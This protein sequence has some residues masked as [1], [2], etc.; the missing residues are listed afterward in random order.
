M[1][2]R[3][4][5]HPGDRH[6]VAGSLRQKQ[7]QAILPLSEW[8]REGLGSAD[9]PNSLRKNPLDS[10]K[11]VG[12]VR[13]IWGAVKGV[14]LEGIPH[15]LINFPSVRLHPAGMQGRLPR[16]RASSTVESCSIWKLN[17]YSGKSKN[18][19][20]RIVPT[21]SSVPLEVS[22]TPTSAPRLFPDLRARRETGVH[23]S[24]E[25]EVSP[26]G[27]NSPQRST[28]NMGEVSRRESP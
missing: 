28:I 2:Q 11:T 19:A 26:I 4:A 23:Q 9:A 1:V 14:N 20:R 15:I 8:K 16:K 17:F 5:A 12:L 27:K 24:E 13:S 25:S 22:Q 18:R 6:R 7:L 21:T 10:R 3:A